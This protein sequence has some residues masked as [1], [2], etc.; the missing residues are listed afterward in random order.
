MR[1]SSFRVACGLALSASG[2]QCRGCTGLQLVQF[3]RIDAVLATP[4]VLAGCVQR[5]RNDHRLQ[6]RRRC[7]CPPEGGHGQHV[8]AQ[9]SSAPAPMLTSR[10]TASTA[11]L[12]GGSN[13]ATARP[14]T[15]SEYLAIAVLYCRPSLNFSC[16]ALGRHGPRSRALD[17]SG[18]RQ[19]LAAASV[20]QGVGNGALHRHVP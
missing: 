16:E 8:I 10:A 18:S 12:S 15:F 13:R 1:F 17:P 19:R 11:A 14:L 7:P 3:V 20:R 2:S 4:G 5:R 6:G 9:R